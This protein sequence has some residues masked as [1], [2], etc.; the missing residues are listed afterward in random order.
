MLVFPM[1]TNPHMSPRT[2]GAAFGQGTRFFCFL[3]SQDATFFGFLPQPW[4]NGLI[5]PGTF[6]RVY[7]HIS[8]YFMGKSMVTDEDFP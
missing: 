8:S 5:F 6:T 1:E 7:P 3:P 4:F 2:P